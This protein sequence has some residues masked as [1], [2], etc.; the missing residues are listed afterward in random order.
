[1]HIDTENQLNSLC[2]EL[3][4][5]LETKPDSYN[6]KQ[7]FLNHKDKTVYWSYNEYVILGYLLGFK[8]GKGA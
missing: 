1:M 2:K 7:Y 3:D 4:F 5:S 6:V 8:K